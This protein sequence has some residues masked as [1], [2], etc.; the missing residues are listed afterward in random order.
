VTYDVTSL[1]PDGLAFVKER[2]GSFDAFLNSWR[3]EIIDGFETDP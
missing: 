3:Q 1:S 2:E